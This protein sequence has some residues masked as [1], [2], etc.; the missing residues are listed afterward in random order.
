MEP[1]RDQCAYYYT[2]DQINNL[3]I[4]VCLQQLTGTQLVDV[5]PRVVEDTSGV[6]EAEIALAALSIPSNDATVSHTH[7]QVIKWQQKLLSAFETVEYSRT[8]YANDK[9]YKMLYEQA[10]KLKKKKQGKQR[11]FTYIHQNKFHYQVQDAVSTSKRQDQ[12]CWLRQRKTTTSIKK[13][14]KDNNTDE[15]EGIEEVNR[16]RSKNQELTQSPQQ[17]Y[18]YIMADLAPPDSLGESRSHEVV[19]CTLRYDAQGQLMVSPDFTKPTS[20]AYRLESFGSDNALYEYTIE[21]ISLC[22]SAEEK[23]HEDQLV[24]QITEQRLEEIEQM[25][26][27][28]WDTQQLEVGELHLLVVGEIMRALHFSEAFSLYIHFVLHLPPG[29]H[30]NSGTECEG[31]TPLCSVGCVGGVHSAHYSTP[32]SFDVTRSKS[33]QGWPILLLAAF[34]VDW[35]GQD[36]DEGYAAFRLSTT[37]NVANDCCREDMV[38]KVHSVATWRP[39]QLSPLSL[40]RRFFI[41]GCQLMADP[42]YLAVGSN[43][44]MKRVSRLGFS[45]LSSGILELRT[46]TVIQGDL[47]ETDFTS[48]MENQSGWQLSTVA[49]IDAFNKSRQKL[50]AAKQGLL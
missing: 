47:S 27:L 32:F 25:V 36:R 7:Q 46:N 37:E 20:K 45:T 42:S 26:G 30:A 3:Q 43:T 50:R 49:V 24:K 23:H 10:M 11:I 33:G 35:L 38:S 1:S 16:K 14:K 19:L 34:S 31:F 21:N 12:E 17:Q 9:K 29:W 22:H 44:E 15:N 6:R 28:E 18:F 39:A 8:L 48:Q 4:R 41:G 5:S 40:M 2:K 13:G